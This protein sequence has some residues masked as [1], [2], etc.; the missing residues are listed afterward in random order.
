MVK[1][2]IEWEYDAE[3]GL[4]LHIKPIPGGLMEGEL[5]QHMLAARKEMLLALRGLID[6]AVKHTEEKE[7]QSPNSGTRI[8]VD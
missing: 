1:G 2:C 8:K 5:H 3:N 4:V 7:S 6:V